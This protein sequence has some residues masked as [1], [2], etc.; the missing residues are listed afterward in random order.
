MFS[1]V[2]IHKVQNRGTIVL[3]SKEGKFAR[4]E[5]YQLSN[6]KIQGHFR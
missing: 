3:F 4:M 6:D 2:K 1:L 5:Y